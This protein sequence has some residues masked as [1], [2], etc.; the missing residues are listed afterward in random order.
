MLSLYSSFKSSYIYSKWSFNSY[1]ASPHVRYKKPA[2]C[3][4]NEARVWT[5][6]RW[7]LIQMHLNDWESV[8]CL[9]Q[10]KRNTKTICLSKLGY[11]FKSFKTDAGTLDRNQTT[12]KSK[13]YDLIF[14]EF[15]LRTQLNRT[16]ILKYLNR[17]SEIRIYIQTNI[18]ISAST[19]DKTIV[20]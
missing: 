9:G 20:R 13:P 14:Y 15:H 4:K 2:T 1:H 10:K 3:L 17:Y 5:L 19:Y 12:K 11:R 6:T 8:R 7:S 18:Q 16:Y